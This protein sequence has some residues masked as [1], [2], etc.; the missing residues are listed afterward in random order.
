MLLSREVPLTTMGAPVSGH[1][2]ANCL[3][4]RASSS[5]TSA[6]GGYMPEPWPA[7]P[8]LPALL[9]PSPPLPPTLLTPAEPP[10]ATVP[11][12]P[13][14]PPEPAAAGCPPTAE[15][16]E[17]VMAAPPLAVPPAFEPALFVAGV[18]GAPS[19]QPTRE[20]MTAANAA[21]ALSRNLT[22]QQGARR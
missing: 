11:A 2:S 9:P 12:T 3:F 15:P 16:L 1:L 7:A 17:P 19:P 8:A 13:T 21:V 14:T 4:T 20:Q 18:E 10:L 5:S 6:A 22:E